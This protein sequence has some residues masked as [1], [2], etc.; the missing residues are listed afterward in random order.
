MLPSL[1]EVYAVA[2]TVERHFTFLAAALRAN[3]AMDCRTEALLLALF[4]N[5]TTHRI[6]SEDYDKLRAIVRRQASK[7]GTGNG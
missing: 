4:A 3:A 6:S 1:L 2:G 7:W 5:R